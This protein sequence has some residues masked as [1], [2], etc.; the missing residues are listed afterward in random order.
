MLRIFLDHFFYKNKIS[1]HSIFFGR[2]GGNCLP[3]PS[4]AATTLLCLMACTA[5]CVGSEGA[6]S[7]DGRQQGGEIVMTCSQSSTGC[8]G[9][10]RDLADQGPLLD[11]VESMS[12]EK[13][14]LLAVKL[15]SACCEMA[16]SLVYSDG[17]TQL[18][19]NAKVLS[20]SIH[21]VSP[22]KRNPFCLRFYRVQYEHIK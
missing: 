9:H 8:R 22:K 20:L 2:G 21:T 10:E 17:S 5:V 11:N 3:C 12:E 19:E 16:L 7:T 1:R 13:R 15:K 14:R 18:R 6:R 4:L